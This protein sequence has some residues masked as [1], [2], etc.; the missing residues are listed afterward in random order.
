MIFSGTDGQDDNMPENIGD[1]L[2]D[3]ASI[4]VDSLGV[5]NFH[6]MVSKAE[7]IINERAFDE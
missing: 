3:I 6:L 1:S 7:S 4:L 5:G 2:H